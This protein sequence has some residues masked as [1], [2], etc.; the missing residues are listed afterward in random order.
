LGRVECTHTL[1][2]PHRGRE[3]VSERSSAKVNQAQVKEEENNEESITA[4][5]KNSE[6][7]KGETNN[8]KIV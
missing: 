3:T 5:K 2:L 4:N 7:C 8:S 6:V 1:P